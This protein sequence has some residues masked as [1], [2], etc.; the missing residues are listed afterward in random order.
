MARPQAGHHLAPDALAR[1]HAFPDDA[2]ALG[3]S[4]SGL[5]QHP[6]RSLG[7]D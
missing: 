1:F 5:T 6:L 2:A 7:R 4:G 3:I